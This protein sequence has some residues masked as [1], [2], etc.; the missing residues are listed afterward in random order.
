[1][2]LLLLFNQQSGGGGTALSIVQSTSFVDTSGA[3]TSINFTLSPTSG[4]ILVAFLS[5]KKGVTYGTPSGTWTLVDN[6]TITSANDTS[7]IYWHA[8]TG[9]EGTS[10][11]FSISGGTDYASGLLYE[12]TGADTTTPIN[13]HSM[14]EQSQSPDYT[15]PAVTP[16]VVGTLPLAYLHSDDGTSSSQVVNSL[17]AGWS[18]V[19]IAVPVWHAS[20]GAQAALTTDTTTA[21]SCI[22]HMSHANWAIVATVLIAPGSGGG[23]TTSTLH[24]LALLGCGS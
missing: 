19:R 4:N 6:H 24:L 18:S 8:V 2:S 12:I 9:S 20:Y 21:Q 17:S 11:S 14:T 5:T 16:T 1:M 7:A 13:A 3:A 15:T 22:F 10:F 23:G